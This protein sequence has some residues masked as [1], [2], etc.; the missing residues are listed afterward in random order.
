M[1]HMYQARGLTQP[2][3]HRQENLFAFGNNKEELTEFVV[4]LPIGINGKAGRVEAA[5]IR[6]PA[7][8]LLEP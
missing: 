6:G 8:L 3:M 7:P 1:M 2:V 5:I 4:E